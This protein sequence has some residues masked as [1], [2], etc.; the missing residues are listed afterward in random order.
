[1]YDLI[2]SQNKVSETEVKT[3]LKYR[4]TLAEFAL[5]KNSTIVCPN[6]LNHMTLPQSSLS[7]QRD[8]FFPL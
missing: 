6:P 1:M 5:F 8:N 7:V 3:Y 2:A 4:I